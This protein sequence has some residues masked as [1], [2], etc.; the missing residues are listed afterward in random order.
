MP[1]RITY[2]PRPRATGAL[3]S[4]NSSLAV[5]VTPNVL[6][7]RTRQDDEEDE[8]EMPQA[9]KVVLADDMYQSYKLQLEERDQIIGQLEEKLEELQV[10]RQRFIDADYERDNA[11]KCLE[12]ARKGQKELL[13]NLES[14]QAQVQALSNALANE[15]AA[16][17]AVQQRVNILQRDIQSSQREL[18]ASRGR[19][20]SLRRCVQQYQRRV[21]S[22]QEQRNGDDMTT[23]FQDAFK[24][25]FVVAFIAAFAVRR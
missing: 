13:V 18:Q 16:R 15:K 9:K 8:D 20:T 11:D 10:Y 14:S 22:M 3:G 1:P 24:G 23:R 19:E 21:E 2:T 5:A 4:N 6:G 7:K 12:S 25:A 17:E